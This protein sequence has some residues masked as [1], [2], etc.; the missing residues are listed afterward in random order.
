[1]NDLPYV[2]AV[3]AAAGEASGTA[4]LAIAEYGHEGQ[5]T[6]GTAVVN[7]NV[8]TA[9]LEEVEMRTLDAI[10]ADVRLD[11]VDFIKIDVEGSEPRVLV[12]AQETL[13]R[14]RPV[15]QLE[16]EPDWLARQNSSPAEVFRLL[17]AA[18]Y[19]PWIFDQT[20]GTLR[21]LEPDEPVN[22]NVIAGANDWRPDGAL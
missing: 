21:E 4:S 14:H 19:A 8:R 3:Q 13:A 12:G 15:L 6:V 1:M 17:D 18:G 11:R 10:L 2:T 16:L 5:N 7:P 22:G 9:S 20:T